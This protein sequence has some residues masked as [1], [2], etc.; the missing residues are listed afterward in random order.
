MTLRE[1][2][3]EERRARLGSR[4]RLA[5]SARTDDVVTI[6]DALVALHSSDPVTVY[7]SATARM[8]TPSI[9]AVEASLYDDRVLV[10]FHAMRR[11]LW[12]ASPA[13]ARLAHASSTPMLAGAERRRL[14]KMLEENGIGDGDKWLDEACAAALASLDDLGE[15]SA[16][17]LGEAVP[18]LRHPLELA[19]GKRYAQTIAAH[20]RVLLQLGLEGEVLRTRPVGSW[21][22]GQYRWVHAT[23]WI[24]GGISGSDPRE[25][26]TELTHR[27][28]RAFGPA[29]AADLQWWT[30]WTKRDTTAALVAAGA[31]PVSVEG[32]EAWIARDDVDV[33][34][35]VEP[36]V[37]FLP[38]LDPTTMGWKERGWYLDPGHAEAAF[39]GN[40]NAGPTIWI[41]GRVVG[42][43]AQRPDGTIAH[44]VFEELPKSRLAA[45]AAAADQLREL[46]GD[47]RISM[48]FPA[49]VTKQLLA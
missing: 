22:S 10:R 39:D 16:R 5:P 24:P 17:E 6:A 40:G 30:G 49:P 37:A 46:L 18:E 25:A 33:V 36:W 28:L 4:H 12:V 45:V 3:V 8:A 21:V 31:E 14:V 2:T 27:W 23:R 42:S 13:V 47:T 9:E 15:A 19:P 43:W 1:V 38:G 11:T 29:S 48:R 32:F 41:D 35:D 34:D 44:V 7:L 26:A 20:T